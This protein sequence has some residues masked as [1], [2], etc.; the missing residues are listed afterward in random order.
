MRTRLLSLLTLPLLV[1]VPLCVAGEPNSR[2]SSVRAVDLGRNVQVIGLL[3]RPLGTI[4]TIEGMGSSRPLFGPGINVQSVNGTMLTKPQFV[5]FDSKEPLV[6]GKSYKL[7]GYETGG[8][9]GDPSPTTKAQQG[10]Q[11]RI[12]FE[13]IGYPD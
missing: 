7:R 8:F 6:T 5:L 13:S 12:R 1:S 10:F 2:T 3:D 9:E 11:F 4:V